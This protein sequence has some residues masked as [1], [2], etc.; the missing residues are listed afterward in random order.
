MLGANYNLTGGWCFWFPLASVWQRKKPLWLKECDP[1]NTPMLGFIYSYG[2]FTLL[3]FL[4]TLKY[5]IFMEHNPKKVAPSELNYFN[6]V[7]TTFLFGS[8]F[9]VWMSADDEADWAGSAFTQDSIGFTQCCVSQ[10][11]R[12]HLQELVS[13]TDIHIH[14][15]VINIMNI[16][17]RQMHLCS[18]MS[19]K[20]FD[21][22][23]RNKSFISHKM[24]F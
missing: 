19:F 10:A 21:C 1:I 24:Y 14:T 18:T 5:F 20:Q 2:V 4:W 22:W 16:L 15:L 23:K 3:I 7:F 9:G 12:V 11:H 8:Y 17:A 6:D 13:S